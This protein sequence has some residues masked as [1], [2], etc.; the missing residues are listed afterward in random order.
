[1]RSRIA[2][3]GLVIGM[4]VPFQVM[5]LSEPAAAGSSCSNSALG[6]SGTTKHG[7]SILEGGK[8]YLCMSGSWIAI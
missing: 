4:S 8:Y 7:G 3:L 1:M 5:V 2:A 6:R